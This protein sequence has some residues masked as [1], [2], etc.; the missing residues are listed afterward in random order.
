[1][2]RSYG[3]IKSKPD[4]RDRLYSSIKPTILLPDSVDM[5]SQCSPVRDQGQLGSCTGFCMATGVMEFIE[6]N[7]P[8][9]IPPPPTP[10]PNPGC[11]SLLMPKVIMNKIF[12][13]SGSDFVVL[14]PMYL[15]YQ[16]R[17]LE[18]TV[19]IDAGAEMRDGMKVLV[20]TGVCPEYDYP[21]DISKFTQKPSAIA[22]TDA[23][24]YKIK[25]YYSL[26]T[27]ND[28]QTALASG[29]GIALG[30]QV[31]ESF[32]SQEVATTGIMPVPSSSERLL[33]GHAVFV[34]GYKPDANAAGG[35]YLIIKNSWGVNWGDH[36]YFY[37]PYEL[38]SNGMVSD[39]WIAVAQ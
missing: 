26:S 15:Y 32:E 22:D 20:N 7:N 30:F 1:M 34:V 2:K 35:G 13:T 39:L 33:G 16:E 19:N 5:R 4:S 25:S 31:Y 37:M 38:L 18:G 24:F 36:G 10:K 6:L 11:L 8:T 3:Y 17:V 28:V 21:Y 9:P 14:S 12:K 27:L 29:N 23:A